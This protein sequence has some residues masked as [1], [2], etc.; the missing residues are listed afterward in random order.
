ME[1]KPKP[2]MEQ[3]VYDKLKYSILHR[4]LAPG[5]Q[6]VESTISEKL[7]VSRTPI[8]NAIKRLSLEGLINIIAN[9]GAFVIQP[10]IDEIVQAYEARIE[11][12]CAAVKLSLSKITAD[13]INKLKLMV[14]DERASFINK[15]MI[16]FIDTNEAFHM[17]LVRKSGNKFLIEFMQKIVNQ[18]NVYLQL[19][20]TFYNVNFEES[21]SIKEHLNIID[22]IEKK[23]SLQLDKALREHISHSFRDLEINKASYKMLNDIF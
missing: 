18:I 14:E 20:D 10:S 5:T 8:R 2:S 23:D 22:M 13:D 4:E 12:E 11:L 1:E 9:R 19:F 21:E 3:I 7:K 16:Q 6:L 15:D 17:T